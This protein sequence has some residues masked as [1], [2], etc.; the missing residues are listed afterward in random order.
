MNQS[1]TSLSDVVSP[2]ALARARERALDVHSVVSIAAPDG[3][4]RY[5]NEPFCEALGYDRG[6]LI[7]NNYAII[8]SGV[9]GSAYFAAMRQ[10]VNDGNSWVGEICNRCKNGQLKWFDNIVVPLF[11]ADGAVNAMLSVRKD[12]TERKT[13]EEKL[14]RSEQLLRDVSKLAK[15][16]GWSL[17]LTT[18]E[19]HWSDQT[20]KLHDVPLDYVPTVEKAVEFY[21]PEVRALITHAVE[22]HIES[23]DGWDLELPLITGKGRSIWVRA[24]GHPI[25]QDGK[26]VSLVGAIQDITERKLTENVLREEIQQRHSTEQLLRDILE[27]LPDAVAAFNEKDELVVCN[28]AYLDTYAIS[29][30]AI[31]PGAS[32]ESILRYGLARGQYPDAGTDKVAQE[33]WLQKRIKVHRNPDGEV[34]QRLRDGT[35]LQIRELCSPTGTRVGVRTDITSLKRAE[36]EL[37]KFAELDPLTGLMNRRSFSAKLNALLDKYDTSEAPVGCVA[38][39]DIDHFKPINDSY[40]HDTGDE[41]LCEVADRLTRL[42]GS[43]GFAARLGGDEFIFAVVGSQEREAHDGLVRALFDAVREPMMTSSGKITLSISLGL[44]AIAGDDLSSR[45]LMKYADLAQYRAKQEGRN[46]WRWFSC[47][48]ASDYRRKTAL[49]KALGASARDGS[50]L[51]FGLLPIVSSQG[52]D[53][54]GFSTA[55]SWTHEGVAY[56][57]DTLSELAHQSG[58]IA[59]LSTRKMESALATFGDA[60]AR[61]IAIGQLWFTASPDYLKLE[62]FVTTIESMRQ[63]YDLRPETITVGVV[64]SALTARS[65]TAVEDTLLA[66]GHLGYRVGIEQ[67]GAHAY[68]LATMQ[69]LGVHAVRLDTSITDPLTDRQSDDRMVRALAE[70]TA[71][72]EIDVLAR[73][74]TTAHQAARLAQIGIAALQGPLVGGPVAPDELPRYLANNAHRQLISLLEIQRDSEAKSQS[75]A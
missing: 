41:V 50:G 73:G 1:G 38:L 53:P 11:D 12:I 43:D 40:G 64:E 9:Q 14:M 67:F 66:L 54:L 49:G 61:V 31:V 58:Q 32:F 57:G 8:D 30:P 39:F 60:H 3:T 68:S 35:W 42:L 33:A 29:A 20:K 5:V 7:G 59:A 4:I 25:R 22:S 70:M 65:S 28:S 48:D 74:I 71:A 46:Q 21:A 62:S 47:E 19:L 17:D 24:I 75:A 55:P 6:E 69:K 26:I 44:V 37:R 56:R 13:S 23:G 34:I 18:E 36:A 15:V 2:E 27:T 10:S 63:R 45:Q 16:G 51:S 52:K 72:L